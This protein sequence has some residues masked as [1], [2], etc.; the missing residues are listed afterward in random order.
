[1]R[2][3]S[4][5][6]GAVSVLVSLT[7]CADLLQPSQTTIELVN[8]GSFPVAVTIYISGTQEIPRDLLTTLGEKIERT[9]P[10]D[11]TVTITRGCDDLQAIVIDDADLQLIGEIGPEADTDIFRDGTHFGCGSTIRFTFTHPLV[12]ISLNIET[13]FPGS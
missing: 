7:G 9:V 2:R 12:P 8:D 6:L 3:L 10:A 4:L 1:M 11:R 13:T 5:V